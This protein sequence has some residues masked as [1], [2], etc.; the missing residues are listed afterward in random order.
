MAL[1]ANN[2]N[3][4]FVQAAANSTALTI[5]PA[6]LIYTADAASRLYG[7]ANPPLGGAVTGFVN[8]E[9]LVN[10]TTGAASFT[11]LATTASNVGSY[12]VSGSGLAANN[13]NYVFVQA[14]ANGTALTITP[15]TLTYVADAATRPY[16]AANPALSGTIVGFAGSDT[17]ANATGG[18]LG[19]STLA[20]T[21]SNVG[22]YLITGAGLTAN[23]GNYTFVQAAANSTALT[24]TPASLTLVYTADGAT[25]VYGAANPTFTGTV[26]GFVGTDTQANA[27]TGTLVFTTLANTA[28]NVGSYLITGSGLTANN[29]NY[30]FTQADRKSVV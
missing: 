8:A 13:G 11:T 1:T 7:A 15:T 22:S 21:A 20:T 4:V 17:L 6:T 12:L 26:T 9:T 2:G 5:T 30:L 29:G 25:R 10:A 3:Y 16:G 14:V 23:N 18:T 28:S 19:F 27:T 24:I